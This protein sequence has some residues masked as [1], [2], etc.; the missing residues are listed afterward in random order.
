MV[1][2]NMIPLWRGRRA[3]FCDLSLSAR[4]RVSR[5]AGQSS[6]AS[7][8]YILRAKFTDERTG[9]IYD[10]RHY[11][12]KPEWSGMFAP[13]DAPEWTSDAANANGYWN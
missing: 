4:D 11:S 2:K 13:K 9:Q 8:A 12:G 1:Q 6:V 7:A 3:P 5:S 10:F